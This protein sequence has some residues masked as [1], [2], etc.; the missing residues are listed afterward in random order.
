[1]AT[2]N[3]NDKVSYDLN[4]YSV[5]DFQY[6]IGLGVERDL[7]HTVA[8]YINVRGKSRFDTNNRFSGILPDSSTTSI[9]SEQAGK[10]VTLL[11]AGLLGAAAIGGAK[12]AYAVAAE[13]RRAKARG[14][15]NLQR[16]TQAGR[17]IASAGGLAIASTAAA[18]TALVASQEN[19]FL[20]PDNKQRLK[21]VITLHMQERPSVK[22][23]VNYQNVDLGAIGGFLGNISALDTAEGGAYALAEAAR[24]PSVIPGIGSTPTNLLGVAA[25]VKTNPFREVL[26]ES[27]DYRTFNFRYKFF[28]K[29]AAEGINIKN[30]ID[31]F[32]FHMHPELSANKFFY[33][34]PS[35]FE[36]RYMFNGAENKNFNKIG[37]CALVDMQ[38]DY[39]GDRFSSFNDGAPTEIDLSLTFRELELMTKEQ[40]K[41]GY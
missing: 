28:P 18:G 23:G 35:E 34:Y 22:Y 21:D 39:G 10:A 25:K 33:I 19:S 12:S 2:K 38:V 16:G 11:G 36:I 41:N 20:K 5:G 37:N 9:T 24:L 7:Q 30:I 8:F 4:K 32:K 13:A 17:Q 26:F 29:S 15:S 31:K 14:L 40:V 3:N 27:V 6:P 1:M